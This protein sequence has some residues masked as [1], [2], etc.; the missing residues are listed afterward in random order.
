MPQDSA[1]SVLMQLFREVPPVATSLAVARGDR[2]RSRSGSAARAVE[3]R[4]YVLEQ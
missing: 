4:E 2:G 1:V 3:Q